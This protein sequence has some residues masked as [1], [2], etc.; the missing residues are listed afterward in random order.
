MLVFSMDVLF[1]LFADA[2]RVAL[3]SE[4]SLIER[5]GGKGDGFYKGRVL[6]M[7][8]IFF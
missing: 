4:R 8:S 7:R 2:R 1:E 6:W 5:G 3:P